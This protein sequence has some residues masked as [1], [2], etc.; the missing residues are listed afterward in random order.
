[1]CGKIIRTNAGLGVHSVIK[2]YKNIK[3]S[4]KVRPVHV[5]FLKIRE[6]QGEL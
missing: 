5:P 4:R 3:D 2:P 1:M 6:G